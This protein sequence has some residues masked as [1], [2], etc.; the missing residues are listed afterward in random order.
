MAE[1][2]GD[3]TRG[4]E[5]AAVRLEVD[6]Q[7]IVRAD[8]PGIERELTGLTLLEAAAV[9]GETLAADAL[10]N[11]IGPALQ[12]PADPGRTAVAM[13]GGVDSAVALLAA[14][15]N[16]VGVTLR[17]WIDPN[18]AASERVCCSPAAVIAARETCHR[19]G[20][21]HVTL[22]LR[23]RFRATVVE[24]FTRDYA[25]GKT[26]NP[27][28]R[29]NGSFRFDELLRFADRIGA[30]RL[31]TGHYARIVA[32]EGGLAI[33][34]AADAAKD[35]SYMLATL[36]PASL[37]RL[38]FPLGEHTKEET[39]ARARAA[40]LAVAG[41]AES[42][43]ACFLGG[44]NYRTFLER[45]GVEAAAG[46]L[47]DETGEQIGS[48]DG[49]W[50]FTPGQ[51]RGLGVAAPE[52][53]YA[54]A[55]DAKTNTVVVGPRASLAR[56]RVAVRGRLD[57]AACRVEAKLRHRSPAVAATVVESPGGFELL[58]D[59]PF[60]GVAPGQTAVLYDDGAIVGSGVIV[61]AA[62]D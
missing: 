60:Y 49:Y 35:Q 27:C 4:G 29:C 30:A 23:E 48:H 55:T 18:A 38:W 50:R 32:R 13:S 37:D 47:V 26:P 61:S 2:F 54:L 28:V 21:A 57:G 15:T 44:D 14:G 1:L 19:L 56:R 41:R 53:L 22:D 10:A 36:D 58:L 8:A 24:P 45:H 7:Q 39:R 17:L 33:A 9:G 42:Q 20:I 11:A 62:A 5:W 40:G 43:E 3:S 34:R 46:T 12:A 51:R 31:A 16:A 6:G 59:E 52:P 25:A